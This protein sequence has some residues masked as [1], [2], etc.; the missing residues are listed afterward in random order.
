MHCPVPGCTAT[1][2]SDFAVV[3]HCES[4]RWSRTWRG[5]GCWSWRARKPRWGCTELLTAVVQ[6]FNAVVD[7][8]EL[9]SAWFQPPNNNVISLFPK[10]A[11]K[12]SLYPCYASVCD[13][14]QGVLRAAGA[15]L[16]RLKLGGRELEARLRGVTAREEARRRLAAQLATLFPNAVQCGSCGFGPVDR[17]ACED[18]ASL[19]GLEYLGGAVQV[20]SS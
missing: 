17:V 19:H 5:G 12:F 6:L 15:E 7:P 18:L 13:Q 14:A 8:P 11:C 16:E 20:E 3:R 1:H 2:Y 9:G 4:P 10:F